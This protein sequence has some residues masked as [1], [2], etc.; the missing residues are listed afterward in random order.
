MS[1]QSS[2][3]VSAKAR[4]FR[5]A[6]EMAMSLAN[7]VAT[8]WILVMMTLLLCD[9]IGR[10]VFGA[11]IAGVPEMVKFSIVGIVFLQVAHTHRKGEMIRSDGL[12]G[13]ISAAMP[14]FGALLDLLAIFA[15]AGVSLL[16]AWA[17]WPKALRAFHR[18]EMEGIAGHFQMPVWPFLT[19]VAV[20]SALL[21]LSFLLDLPEAARRL[22]GKAVQP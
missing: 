9:I 11:P 2:A 3:S 18:G 6:F 19:I 22:R 1:Q 12:L 7:V 15:G 14:R 5:R 17:V 21:A 16:L 20:G 13:V 8:A 10:D 4:P